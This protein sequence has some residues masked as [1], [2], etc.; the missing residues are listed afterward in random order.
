MNL[1]KELRQY[2]SFINYE[3][4]KEYIDK[5][6]T[7][8]AEEILAIIPSIKSGS[9]GPYLER[10]FL[11]SEN[12]LC[13]VNVN[14]TGEEFDFV[15]LGSITNYRFSLS[16]MTVKD[17]N[18]EEIKYQVA[19]VELIHDVGTTFH[20]EFHYVGVKREEWLEHFF[21]ELPLSNIVKYKT[22]P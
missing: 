8:L 16:E 15:A 10:L 19:T 9:D 7:A 4:L 12:Y 17:A 1:E 14:T 3:S 11:I 13:D 21:K 2:N 18:E 6:K 22:I 20:T 5:P